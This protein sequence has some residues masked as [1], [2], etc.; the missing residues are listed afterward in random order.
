MITLRQR[1]T[2]QRVEEVISVLLRIGVT[3]AAGV[4]LIGGI[5]YLVQYGVSQPHYQHFH[6][7]PPQ[8]HTLTGI[9]SALLSLDSR[10]II[11]FGLLLL[12]LTPIARVVFSVFAF[13]LQQDRFYVVV[14]AIVLVVLLINLLWG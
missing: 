4:V 5:L 14:T 11:Q 8:F 13:M 10:A 7:E 6:R 12:I 2:D 3:S 9:V 1:W